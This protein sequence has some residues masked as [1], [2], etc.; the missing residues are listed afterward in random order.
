[1]T[2]GDRFTWLANFRGKGEARV[3]N[4]WES[5]VNRGSGIQWFWNGGD[6]V[7]GIIANRRLLS[8]AVAKVSA[9]HC[10]GEG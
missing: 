7:G 8:M 10:T 2:V 5:T 9:S 4:R 3:P 1:M 6:G